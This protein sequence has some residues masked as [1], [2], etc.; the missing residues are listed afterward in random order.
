MK[1]KVYVNCEDVVKIEVSENSVVEVYW[2]SSCRG[3]YGGSEGDCWKGLKEIKEG[4]RN[5]NSEM[6]MG[7]S[8]VWWIKVDGELVYGDKEDWKSWKEDRMYD[9]EDL[10][11]GNGEDDEDVIRCK[12]LLDGL[13]EENWLNREYI[14]EIRGLLSC[15]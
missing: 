3:E 14:G 1:I 15:F 10:K 9:W 2:D 6:E 5:L 13:N 4:V 12:D 11:E 7:E 8:D